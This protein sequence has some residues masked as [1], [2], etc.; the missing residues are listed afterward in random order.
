MTRTGD[1]FR[2]EPRARVFFLVLTQSAL[3]TGAAYVALLLVAYER[4][5]SPWA[6]SAVLVADL[7]PAMLFGPLLGAVADRW[8]RRLCAVVADLVRVVAFGGLVLVDSFE[9]TVALAFLAGV[10]TALFTPST[11][12][13][14][15]SL[16]DRSRLPAATSVYGAISDFGLAAGPGAG[17]VVLLVSGPESLLAANSVTFAVSA[18]V[19]LRLPFGSAPEREASLPAPLAGGLLS[20]AREGLS[21]IAG[22]P[23]LWA[24]LGASGAALVFGGLVNVAELPFITEDLDASQAYYSGAVALAGGGIVLGSLAGGSG[25]SV[26]TLRRRYLQGLVVMGV[27]FVLSGLAPAV[28]VIL[29]TFFIAGLGNG[30]MLVYER[31]IVLA[32]IPD[33]LAAR[34]FSVKDALSAWAFAVA[35]AASGGLIAL[36]G[37]RAVILTAGVGVVLV[38]LLAVWALRG[39]L[40]AADEGEA[41]AG[42]GAE[43]VRLGGLSEHRPNLVSGGDHWL[44]L[45][46]DLND[47]PDD[48]RVE[49]R[50]GVGD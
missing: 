49:L 14:L 38:S 23:G 37:S 46:D 50:P 36:A 11:L 35:F 1:L 22:F 33:R 20:E 4:F 9:A 29:A 18:L 40:L 16:V 39:R 8:S 28:G 27:G 30:V 43:V 21:S 45:L 31:L 15:P 5:H 41:S 17:A 34:I 47:G 44:T 19:L 32:T 2:H 26:R 24:V 7:L 25:G 10:G 3:G 13:A 48:P 42:A 6:I 12:A